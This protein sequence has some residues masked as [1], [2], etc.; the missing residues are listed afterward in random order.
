M[1]K[2]ILHVYMYHYDFNI[3]R[4]RMPNCGR[5]AVIKIE[6]RTMCKFICRYSVCCLFYRVLEERDISRKLQHIHSNV[7][8]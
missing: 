1:Y 7:I 3:F 5:H 8:T 6:F 2:V 4:I